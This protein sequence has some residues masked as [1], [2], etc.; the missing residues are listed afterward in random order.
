MSVR[1]DTVVI[2]GGQAGLTIG[3]FLS[4]QNRSFVILDA[5]E[6][7][8][9]A[10]RKRWAS[11]RL[12]T[13]ARYNGL[14]G[15]RFPGRAWDFPTKDEMADYLET[16]AERFAL[17]IRTGVRVERLSKENGTFVVSA[18]GSRFEADNVV[19]ATGF[20]RIPKVPSFAAELDPAIVQVHSS[21]YVEP[22]QLRDGRVLVVGVCNSG[23]EIAHELAGTRDCVLAGKNAGQIPVR[24][25]SRPARMF[26]RI[27]RFAQHHV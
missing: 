11:L 3:Y 16:Y 26:L 8:G 5:N 15:L 18:N 24:H 12:F 17:P 7:V 21:E 14:P 13:P 23:A 10:W 19:V 25:G 20:Y 1:Y 9:D 27:F 4:K 6:R 2:G 22:A